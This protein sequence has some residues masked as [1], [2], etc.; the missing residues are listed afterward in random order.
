MNKYCL[1][2][3]GLA[4][5]FTY[6]GCHSFEPCDIRNTDCQSEVFYEVLELRGEQWD[7]WASP[8][9]MSVI[10]EQEY[11]QLLEKDQ[12]SSHSSSDTSWDTA[13]KLLHL[14]DANVNSNDASV[15]SHVKKVL[16]FYSRSTKQ[17]TIIDHGS[18][19][20]K[21]DSTVTLAH[22]IV[23]ALQ[24]RSIGLRN[25]YKETK[26]YDASRA[27]ACM[28]EGEARLYEL[29]L[30]LKI[31][32]F[33]LDW[34]KYFTKLREGLASSLTKSSSVFDDAG[35]MA[36]YDVGLMYL[37]PIYARGGNP[38]VEAAILSKPQN[39]AM[40]LAGQYNVSREPLSCGNPIT[41]SGFQRVG[42]DTFGA[43]GLYAFSVKTK[44]TM[45]WDIMKS[46]SD[47][48]IQVYSTPNNSIA[49]SWS[50]RMKNRFYLSTIEK[51]AVDIGARV[52]RK[53]NTN[54]I[55]ILVAENAEVLKQWSE[56]ASGCS[57]T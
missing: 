32:D 18:V 33:S 51:I 31:E 28:I 36:V 29:L 42:A 4:V 3:L 15:D 38:A 43:I 27:R 39:T 17:V 8:P 47:D 10:S 45:S 41:P 53:N 34:S 55:I 13:L 30:Y 48:R 12:N 26:S 23:H 46:W 22:E 52:I 57:D 19:V 35:F 37:E 21:E 25:Y 44:A 54:E 9:P 2:V 20:N 7:A 16:A 11:R 5:L 1:L 40:L 24:D 49:V 56:S 50:I 14:L 6:S